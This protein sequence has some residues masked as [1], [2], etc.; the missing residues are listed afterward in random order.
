MIGASVWDL[1]KLLRERN[2]SLRKKDEVLIHQSPSIL[3]IVTS[4]V[5]TGVDRWEIPARLCGEC[6]RTRFREHVYQ[7]RADDAVLPRLDRACRRFATGL[8]SPK[9][10]EDPRLSSR[11]LRHPRA[12]IRRVP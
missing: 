11:R 8:S 6:E 12:S 5:D 2:P 10:M 3:R 9:G 7:L 4:L 1:E